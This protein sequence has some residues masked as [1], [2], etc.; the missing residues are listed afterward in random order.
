[1]IGRPY[2]GKPT[3]LF[4]EG[5]LEIEPSAT[6]PALHCTCSLERYVNLLYI[7]WPFH[8]YCTSPRFG[9]RWNK[10]KVWS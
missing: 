7:N 1:M 6:T 3:V 5:E 8:L 9:G 4:D 10:E 2:S